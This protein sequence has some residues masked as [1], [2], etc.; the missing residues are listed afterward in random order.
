MLNA[1]FVNGQNKY[2]VINGK[3]YQVNDLV[4]GNKL[5]QIEQNQAVLN[6]SSGQK[7]LF[8]NN[9]NIKKDINDGF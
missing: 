8:I 7:T 5:I 1:V 6:T 3:Q 4:L 2:A 9:H